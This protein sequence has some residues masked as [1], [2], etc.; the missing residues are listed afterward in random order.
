MIRRPTMN[1]RCD[2]KDPSDL[3]MNRPCITRL[4]TS[5]H[6]RPVGSFY[7][8]PL[9]KLTPQILEKRS[10]GSFTEPPLAHK[11]LLQ[12]ALF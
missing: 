12:A 10:D 6:E 8:A 9:H 11:A 4:L 5:W 2:S 3:S 7:E 1:S